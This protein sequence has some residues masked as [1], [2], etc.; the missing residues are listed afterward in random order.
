MGKSNGFALN[1]VHIAPAITVYSGSQLVVRLGYDVLVFG[2][3]TGDW[4]PEQASKIR[5]D[6][7]VSVNMRDCSLSRRKS[8][9]VERGER[10]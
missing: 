10:I 9:G 1:E 4:Q 8:T 7:S 2:P 6:H 3:P 5:L